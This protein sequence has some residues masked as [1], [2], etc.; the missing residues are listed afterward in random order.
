MDARYVALCHACERE[1]KCALG[2]D[3][4]A[5]DAARVCRDWTEQRGHVAG[6]VGLTSTVELA[7]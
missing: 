7:F 2:F 5:G 1:G 3:V 4:R 6:P